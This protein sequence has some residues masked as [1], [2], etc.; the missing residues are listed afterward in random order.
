MNGLLKVEMIVISLL[1]IV[2][3]IYTLKNN[4]LSVKYSVVWLIIPIVFLGFTIFSEPMIKFAN[5]LGFELLSNFIFF[6]IFGIFFIICFSLTIIT[7][8]LKKRIVELT[9]EISLLK[10]EK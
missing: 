10:G 1:V 3:I 7:T 6:L 8:N 4:N 9:Q 5:F 2:M